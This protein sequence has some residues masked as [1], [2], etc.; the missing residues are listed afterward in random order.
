MAEPRYTDNYE[1]E[2]DYDAML[3]A[4]QD[5]SYKDFVGGV[6]FLK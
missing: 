3:N 2:R 1:S 5:A 4:L 6:N